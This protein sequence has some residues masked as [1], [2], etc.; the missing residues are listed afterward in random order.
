MTLVLEEHYLYLSITN[1]DGIFLTDKGIPP[2]GIDIVP[3][4]RSSA[5]TVKVGLQVWFRVE[6]WLGR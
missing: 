3:Q 2:A 6:I 4:S 1:F 5:S